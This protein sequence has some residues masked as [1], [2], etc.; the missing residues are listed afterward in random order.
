M[1]ERQEPRARLRPLRDEGRRRP[2]EGEEGLLNRVLGQRV[3]PE[4]AER[5]AV[6]DPAEPVVELAERR[7]VTARQQSHE[8]L[9]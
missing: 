7:L 8:G 9:V 6:C 2:P 4:D 1:H 3:V 5:E